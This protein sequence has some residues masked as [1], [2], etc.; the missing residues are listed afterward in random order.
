MMLVLT[1]IF[2]FIRVFMPHKAEGR[3]VEVWSH[4]YLLLSGEDMV[5]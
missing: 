1:W 5:F 4:L 3:K 2:S